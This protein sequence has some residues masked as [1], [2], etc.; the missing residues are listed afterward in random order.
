M[1]RSKTFSGLSAVITGGASGIGLALGRQLVGR[2]AHVTLA[3]IDAEAA[4]EH[5]DRMNRDKGP[6]SVSGCHLDVRDESAFRAVIDEV[7]ARDGHLDLLFNN[8]GIS[9]GG[10]DRATHLR[11]LGPHHRREHQGGRQRSDGRLSGD[12]RA[13]PRSHHQHRKW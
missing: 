8:A 4:L 2:G 1:R 12:G 13:G 6:G 11:S 7:V 5:A 9:M 3:D 10:P